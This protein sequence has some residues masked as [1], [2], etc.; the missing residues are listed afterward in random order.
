MSYSNLTAVQKDVLKEIGNIG[1][2]NAATA[3]SVLL[4]E[5]IEIEVPSVNVVSFDEMME[6]IGGPEELITSLFFRIGGDAPSS[7]YL[8]LGM[9][10]ADNLARRMTGPALAEQDQQN[11]MDASALKEVANII[12]GTYL[13]ALSEFTGLA[14]RPTVPHLGIDMAG[15][16]L[17]V[18]LMQVSPFADHAIII[19]T[20]IQ[21]EG[22]S[23][24]IQ[25]NFL[26]LPDPES[27]STI[28]TSLGLEQNE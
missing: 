12:T 23:D 16:L 5:R 20:K 3:L 22:G 21:H 19:D 2:G 4:G 14:F 7:V 26:M 15:A 28:F 24:G 27:L 18:G 9:D 6:L 8:I 11:G 25:G 10:E 13:S 1:A 17:T